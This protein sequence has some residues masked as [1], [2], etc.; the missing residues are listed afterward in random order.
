MVYKVYMLTWLGVYWWD[1]WSTIYSSTVRIR[2]W[3][4][5]SPCRKNPGRVPPPAAQRNGTSLPI[6][7]G[8][9]VSAQNALPAVGAKQGPWNARATEPK[10]SHFAPWVSTPDR[11]Q[12]RD[13]DIL[14]SYMVDRL[15]KWMM[16][17]GGHI[18]HGEGSCYNVTQAKQR[19]TTW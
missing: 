12:L 1:P 8:P 2:C 10:P 18:T 9:W 6:P 7:W 5:D 19:K 4:W 11:S 3:D 15:F 17:K 13:C 16:I 14:W